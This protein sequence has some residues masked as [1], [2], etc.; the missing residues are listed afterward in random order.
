[1]YFLTVLSL[2]TYHTSVLSRDPSHSNFRLLFHAS[3]CK[4][5]T[6]NQKYFPK[7]KKKRKKYIF[8]RKPATWVPSS[9]SVSRSLEFRFSYFNLARSELSG[10]AVGTSTPRRTSTVF[11]VSRFLSISH[12]LRRECTEGERERG[13]FAARDPLG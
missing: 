10:G 13:E 4:T 9:V 7:K 1:M 2:F 6:A 8:N 3:S 11:C 12:S 5:S